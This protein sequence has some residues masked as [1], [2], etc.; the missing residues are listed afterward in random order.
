MARLEVSDALF[1]SRQLVGLSSAILSEAP[2]LIG[3]SPRAKRQGVGWSAW[4]GIN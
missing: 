3:I 1:G 4:L 2:L